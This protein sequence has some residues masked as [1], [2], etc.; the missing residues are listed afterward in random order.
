MMIMIIICIHSLTDRWNRDEEIRREAR[1]LERDSRAEL[2]REVLIEI[3]REI[4]G[5]WDV[6][7]GRG[8]GRGR[9][10]INDYG[11]GMGNRR[12]WGRGRRD[13]GDGG[14][15]SSSVRGVIYF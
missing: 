9:G 14:G 12:G 4:Q 3:R 1:R 2:I 11:R 8:R 6:G 5:G 15:G 13:G 10:D 7:R